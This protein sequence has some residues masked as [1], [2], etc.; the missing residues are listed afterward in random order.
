MKSVRA[1]RD[2]TAGDAVAAVRVVGCA[3]ALTALLVVAAG[4]AFLVLL[5]PLALLA[6]LNPTL[7][8][9]GVP[10][11]QYPAA[12]LGVQALWTALVGLGVVAAARTISLPPLATDDTS[13]PPDYPPTP[14]NERLAGLV[15]TVTGDD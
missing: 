8:F 2:V 10:S 5:L 13:L 14:A 1:V 12:Y 15:E 9:G 7:T 11:T 6:T 3:L 4:A